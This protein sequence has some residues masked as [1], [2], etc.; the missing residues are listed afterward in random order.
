MAVP[1]NIGA[2]N[3]YAILPGVQSP[4]AAYDPV[5]AQTTQPSTNGNGTVGTTTD[6]VGVGQAALNNSAVGQAVYLSGIP[7]LAAGVYTLLPAKYAT[8]PGAFRV[9]LASGSAPAL[10][11]RTETL[12][13]GTVVAAGYMANTLTGSRSATPVLFDV[14]SGRSGS[15]TRNIRSP[16]PTRSSRRSQRAPGM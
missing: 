3:V 9:T 7:G 16:V 11:G 6:S 13:D 5:F 14:Q 15:N 12:P 1:T 8:L 10:P 4:V 2:T